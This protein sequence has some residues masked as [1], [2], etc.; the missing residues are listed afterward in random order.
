MKQ[1]RLLCTFEFHIDLASCRIFAAMSLVLNVQIILL[2]S[3]TDFIHSKL[4]EARGT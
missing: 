1:I 4:L 3:H 2:S